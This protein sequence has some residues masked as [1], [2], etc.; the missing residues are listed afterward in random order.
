MNI[1][2]LI[3]SSASNTTIHESDDWTGW[4]TAPVL[5]AATRVASGAES[6]AEDSARFSRHA[7]Y[8]ASLTITSANQFHLSPVDFSRWF[9][10]GRAEA[11]TEWL[12]ESTSKATERPDW[13]DE[14]IGNIRQLLQ[15]PSN[16]D[17]YDA[18]PIGSD[19]TERSID[20]F[21]DILNQPDLWKQLPAPRIVPCPDGGIQL[22][23]DMNDREIE[24][25]VPESSAEP[26]EYLAV[27]RSGEKE[28]TLDHTGV[29]RSLYW[30]VGQ[31]GEL[32][33]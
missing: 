16:W 17:S 31:Q 13:L 23:W 12:W 3:D 25:V 1:S 7:F 11:W 30:L 14:A 27:D 33:V 5:R 10:A 26:I 9:T 19:A 15:L 18:A 21:L 2:Y 4:F 6:Y 29:I 32:G 24:I 22:E 20:V 8:L 28:G